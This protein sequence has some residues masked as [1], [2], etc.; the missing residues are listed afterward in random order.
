MR[1]LTLLAVLAAGATLATAAPAAAHTLH[2]S[3]P[4]CPDDAVCFWTEPGFEGERQV[5]RP[6]SG[7]RPCITTPDAHAE[8]AV[9]NTRFSRLLYLDPDCSSRPVGFIPSGGNTPSLDPP[10]AAWR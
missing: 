9:N 2:A 7:S 3:D 1:C 8:S 5:V 6:V 10:I 4:R